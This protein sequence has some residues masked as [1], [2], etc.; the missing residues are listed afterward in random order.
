M[1]CEQCKAKGYDHDAVVAACKGSIYQTAVRLCRWD[2]IEGSIVHKALCDAIQKCYTDGPREVLLM[3]WRW[4]MKSTIVVSTIIWGLINNPE[5]RVLMEHA[6]AD[7]SKKRS[8][9]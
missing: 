3:I 2:R 9:S 7:E 6:S 1:P 8:S 4:G 5:L